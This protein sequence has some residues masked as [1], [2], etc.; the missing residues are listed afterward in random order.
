MGNI[1]GKK[2]ENAPPGTN[3][4]IDH[5]NY[6]PLDKVYPP[7]IS[8]QINTSKTPDWK[9]SSPNIKPFE[10]ISPN[11]MYSLD[12]KSLSNGLSNKN[13]RTPTLFKKSFI[14]DNNLKQM[15][16]YY[17]NIFT[18]K[19]MEPKTI[20]EGEQAK[21]IK[22]YSEKYKKYLVK[23]IIKISL[24]QTASIKQSEI[25]NKI[26]LCKQTIL[27]SI[28]CDHPNIVKIYDFIDNPLTITM[29]YC[30]KG[31]LRKIL[32]QNI[33]LPPI[34]KIFLIRSI[35]DGLGYMH[36]GGIIHGDLKCDNILLSD[37]YRY[38]IGNK[39]YPIP[40]LAD[41]GLAQINSNLLFAGTPGFMSPEVYKVQA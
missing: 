22:F 16:K 26:N 36:Y 39:Y 19:K 8:S 15:I 3:I 13:A 35:C 7:Y 11:N 4:N 27:L 6:P 29:E 18:I 38:Y 24:N 20:G 10:L 28:R 25:L 41:F 30:A 33:Y 9:S 5:S 32:D 1:C 37:E 23:Q 31:S 21:I 17:S 40:K 12:N 34:Y 14:P 2:D